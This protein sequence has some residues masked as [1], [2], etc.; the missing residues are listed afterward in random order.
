MDSQREVSIVLFG[1]SGNAEDKEEQDSDRQSFQYGT[2][3]IL[4]HTAFLCLSESLKL[5]GSS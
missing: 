4:A 1:E 5:S 3:R 2:E